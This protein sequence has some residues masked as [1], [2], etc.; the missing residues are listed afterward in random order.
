MSRRRI[1]RF[2]HPQTGEWCELRDPDGP[3]TGRQLMK[4]N[5]AGALVVVEPGQSTPLSKGEA[6]AVIDSVARD[7]PA[8]GASA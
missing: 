8:G 4:L 6:A 5:H 1:T 7:D 2:I 3:A